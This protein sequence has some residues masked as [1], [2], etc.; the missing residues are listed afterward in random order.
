MSGF[1]GILGLVFTGLVVANLTRSRQY[2]HYKYVLDIQYDDIILLY[3]I[4]SGNEVSRQNDKTSLN[5]SYVAMKKT[6][7]KGTSNEGS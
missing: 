3:I 2:S 5:V 6:S 7:E 1:Y 4:R